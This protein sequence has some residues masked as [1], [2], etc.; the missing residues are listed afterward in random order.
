[1]NFTYLLKDEAEVKRTAEPILQFP[2]HRNACINSNDLL[3]EKSSGKKN[4]S[5]D[6]AQEPCEAN[7]ILVLYCINIA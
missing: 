1:M 5:A 2:K 3:K 7:L 4:S 6:E